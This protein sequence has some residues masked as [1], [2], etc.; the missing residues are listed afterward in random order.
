MI[1]YT[2]QSVGQFS[3]DRAQRV[4]Y[5]GI[6]SMEPNGVMTANSKKKFFLI[7]E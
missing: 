4:S 3:I 1:K 2:H 6:M 5:D 7:V